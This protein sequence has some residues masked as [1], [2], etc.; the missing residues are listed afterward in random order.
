MKIDIILLVDVAEKFVKTS[1]N[2]HGVNPLYCVSVC[3]YTLQCAFEKKMISNY[4]HYKI[5]LWFC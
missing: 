5:G 1:T 4:K 3:I 2:E